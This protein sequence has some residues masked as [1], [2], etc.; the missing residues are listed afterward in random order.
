MLCGRCVYTR[1]KKKKRVELNY[2]YVSGQYYI[3][4]EGK[5]VTDRLTQSAASAEQREDP[6]KA[7][8]GE[9][10]RWWNR[11]WEELRGN[12]TGRTERGGGRRRTVQSLIHRQWE[13]AAAHRLI[14]ASIN[15]SA[16]LLCVLCV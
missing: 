14:R 16:H 13:A 4:S 10:S 7:G 3:E 15:H 2:P 12:E 1:T 11:S 9:V 6:I 8:D 5:G